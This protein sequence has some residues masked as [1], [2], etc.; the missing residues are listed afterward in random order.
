MHAEKRIGCLHCQ[1]IHCK[2]RC[3]FLENGGDVDDGA[4]LQDGVSVVERA[5]SAGSVHLPRGL[6]GRNGLERGHRVEGLLLLL[7]KQLIGQH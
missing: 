3:T 7:L 5:S 6:Y 1:A 4:D 2:H